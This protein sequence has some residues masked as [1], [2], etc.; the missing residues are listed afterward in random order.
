MRVLPN[1]QSDEINA[2]KSLLPRIKSLATKISCVNKKITD[3]RVSRVRNFNC[4]LLRVLESGMSYANFLK[5]FRVETGE[6]DFFHYEYIRNISQLNEPQLP[7][8]SA[9]FQ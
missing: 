9:F 5:D 4:D 2:I 7:P 6:N 8:H 1:S 3:I